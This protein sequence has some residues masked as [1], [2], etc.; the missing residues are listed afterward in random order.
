M[1]VLGEE[2]NRVWGPMGKKARKETEARGE[3]TVKGRLKLSIKR[4]HVMGAEIRRQP[5]EATFVIMA[6]RV[7]ALSSPL[8]FVLLNEACAKW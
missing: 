7:A 3:R 2:L 1:Y 8:S 4:K 5:G 6:P